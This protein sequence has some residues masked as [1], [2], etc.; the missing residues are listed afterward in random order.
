LV[1]KTKLEIF[2]GTAR[3][4]YNGWISKNPVLPI[5]TT[6]TYFEIYSNLRGGVCN[7]HCSPCYLHTPYLRIRLTQIYTIFIYVLRIDKYT[8]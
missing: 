6:R 4:N 8:H 1:P 3:K 2:R 7:S 5:Q